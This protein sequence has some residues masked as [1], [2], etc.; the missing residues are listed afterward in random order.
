[1][2]EIDLRAL[3]SLDRVM[4]SCNEVLISPDRVMRSWTTYG[5]EITEWTSL[6]LKNDRVLRAWTSLISRFW[7]HWTG[8]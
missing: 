3:R 4:R 2:D 7:D 1:M 6:M 5:F 8:F